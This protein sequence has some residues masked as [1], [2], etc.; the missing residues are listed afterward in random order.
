MTLGPA[1][2]VKTPLL[3]TMAKRQ[4]V[5]ATLNWDPRRKVGMLD[6]LTGKNQQYDLDILALMF[7]KNQNFL[8]FVGAEAQDSLD[9]SGKIY[10]SGDDQTGEGDTDDEF[11][12]AELAELPDAIEHIVFVVEVRSNHTFGDLDTVARIVDSFSHNLLLETDVG[13]E[14]AVRGSK[15]FVF[16]RIA[17]DT[18]SPTGWMVHHIGEYPDLSQ[19]SDWGSYLKKYL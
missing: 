11:I 12:T 9:R 8:D 18:G 16:A 1:P 15:A 19:V 14:N 3:H 10:H 6:K 13:V 5:L 2:G 17:R 7:D 4:R